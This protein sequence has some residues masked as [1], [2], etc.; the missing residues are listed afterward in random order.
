MIK[1]KTMPQ[2]TP[3]DPEQMMIDGVAPVSMG[4]RLGWFA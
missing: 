3:P 1:R 4:E 2:I